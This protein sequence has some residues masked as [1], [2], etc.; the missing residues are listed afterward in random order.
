[1][2]S[3]SHER[4]SNSVGVPAVDSTEECKVLITPQRILQLALFSHV[5]NQHGVLVLSNSERSH[6]SNISCCYQLLTTQTL[7]NLLQLLQGPT[8]ESSGD[9]ICLTSMIFGE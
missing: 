1:M 9:W 2:Y 8:S 4:T 3:T 6:V 7:E 5:F